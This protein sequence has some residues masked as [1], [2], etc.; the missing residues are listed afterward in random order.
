MVHDSIYWSVQI[1][2]PIYCVL[3][4]DIHRGW[5]DV[6][7]TAIDADNVDKMFRID[8]PLLPEAEVLMRGLCCSCSIGRR[9]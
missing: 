9:R 1:N 4:E 5:R 2:D 8:M 7:N 6:T 3:W